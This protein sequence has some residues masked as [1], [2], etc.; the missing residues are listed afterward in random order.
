[1]TITNGVVEKKSTKYKKLNDWLLSWETAQS[2]NLKK[3]L[4]KS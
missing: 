2:T 1:M 3:L 4:N